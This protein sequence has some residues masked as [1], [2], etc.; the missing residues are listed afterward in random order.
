MIRSYCAIILGLDLF[1]VIG[2]K[3]VQFFVKNLWITRQVL[4]YIRIKEAIAAAP[5][6][7]TFDPKLYHAITDK[8]VLHRTTSIQLKLVNGMVV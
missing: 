8:I 1:V 2:K 5:P 3:R 4:A 7:D 6:C